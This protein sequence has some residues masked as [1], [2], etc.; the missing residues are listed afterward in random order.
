MSSVTSLDLSAASLRRLNWCHRFVLPAN[1]MLHENLRSSHLPRDTDDVQRDFDADIAGGR[2][3]CRIEFT[4]AG[5]NPSY[6][7]PELFI[8]YVTSS[9]LACGAC[10]CL[11][12]H[13]SFP[14]A[15]KFGDTDLE[16]REQVMD[17]F[18]LRPQ[19]QRCPSCGYCAKDAS[20]SDPRFESVM[21]QKAYRDHLAN[22]R[23]LFVAASFICAA[24]LHSA[25]DYLSNDQ[26]QL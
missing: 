24:L 17:R 12:T 18:V 23:Y 4:T 2:L 21:A 22:R 9:F 10:R 15:K 7:R 6:V 26:T 11:F 25:I 19:I 14:M 5:F 13:Q 3:R 1:F 16:T 8:I 20:V